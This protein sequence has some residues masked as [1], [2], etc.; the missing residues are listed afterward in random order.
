MALILN[1]LCWIL[2]YFLISWNSV[3]DYVPALSDCFVPI[4]ETYCWNSIYLSY[5]MKCPI[6]MWYCSMLEGYFSYLIKSEVALCYACC[7]FLFFF[8]GLL[9]Y[10]VICFRNLIF[11][12][13]AVLLK[14]CSSFIQVLLF[15]NFEKQNFYSSANYWQIP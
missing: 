1:A 2:E 3:T 15:K 10:T 9:L 11:Q 12:V 13:L 7:F 5:S 6:L 4:I 8:N 14:S